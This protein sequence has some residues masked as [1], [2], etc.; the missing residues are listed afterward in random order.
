MKQ[1][2]VFPLYLD[3]YHLTQDIFRLTVKFSRDYKFVLGNRLNDATIDLCLC[4]SK[5]IRARNKMIY[6]EEI[7]NQLDR[8]KLELRL[9]AD[10]NLFSHAQ[11]ADLAVCFEKITT[12]T[13]TWLKS[14][15][16]KTQH[17]SVPESGTIP[18]YPE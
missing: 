16:R 4:I 1:K 18:N 7:L 17:H 13:L 8:I 9:C 10:F 5:A 11:Q 6:L 15:R 3:A 2:E 14:E 12:Q